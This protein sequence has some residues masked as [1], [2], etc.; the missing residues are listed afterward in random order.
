ME[1]DPDFE[2]AFLLT[3]PELFQHLALYSEAFRDLGSTRQLGALGG[4]GE[5]PWTAIDRYAERLGLH[6]L[7]AFERLRWALGVQDRVYLE[8]LAEKARASANRGGK[9]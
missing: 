8:H 9:P 2:P 1:A 4:A 5:I 6:D 7:D 3:R